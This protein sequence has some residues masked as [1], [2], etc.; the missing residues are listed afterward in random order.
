M[1]P[2]ENPYSPPVENLDPPPPEILGR[3]L[4]RKIPP[5]TLKQFVTN[6]VTTRALDMATSSSTSLYPIHNYIDCHRFSETH[7]VYMV[8]VTSGVVPQFFKQAVQDGVSQDV[9]ENEISAH[10]LNQTW[11]LEDLPL[12]KRALGSK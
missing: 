10:E 5:V 4:R 3:G 8:A 1:P 9:M 7:K 6:T 11:T 2:V 12:G